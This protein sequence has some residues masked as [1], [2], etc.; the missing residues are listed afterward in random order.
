MDCPNEHGKM[1]IKAMK[2]EVTFRDKRI[3]YDAEHYVCPVC[4]TE[5][6]D[7]VL[8]AE[9]Q[10]RISDAYRKAVN[11]LTG[12]EIV[13][14]RKKLK[15]SQARLAEAMSVG[16]ASVKRWET[17]QIQTKPMDDTLRRVLSGKPS[18]NNPYAG[19]RSLSLQRIKRVLHQFSK[20]L[21][22][23]MLKDDPGDVLL[24]EAKYIWL[25]D[26]ISFRETGRGM[27]GAT[28]A[29][30]PQGPQ[31]NNYRDLVP[32]IK[33]ANEDEAEP[34]TDHEIRIISRIAA[35]YPTNKSI[36]DASHNEDA[37]KTRRDGELMLYTDAESVRAL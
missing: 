8:A 31:L 2:K 16:I 34:L 6:D 27:T 15:W 4:G 18:G 36:Y 22:R 19:N 24:Y 28:Y 17:G 12:Q 3:E 23:D 26:I 13:I 11:L 37:Y 10:K 33:A 1:V 21:D 5:V 25:A 29:R 14:G 35:A 32:M 30:L 20:T 9:N 7:L